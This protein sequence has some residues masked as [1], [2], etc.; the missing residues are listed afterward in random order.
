MKKTVLLLTAAVTGILLTSCNKEEAIL[1]PADRSPQN[2]EKELQEIF[3]E[4]MQ[5]YTSK[6]KSSGILAVP[7]E[8]NENPYNDAG[9]NHN[10]V[11]KFI[12]SQKTDDLYE[13]TDLVKSEF[14][15]TKNFDFT[16]DDVQNSVDLGFPL[17]IKNDMII[18][19]IYDSL[20]A[21][22]KISEKERSILF[23]TGKAFFDANNINQKIQIVKVAE[24]YILRSSD[25][26]EN[27]E[28][29]ML[30]SFAILRYS[31]YYWEIEV[32]DEIEFACAECVEF[33]D[34][35]AAVW[36]LHYGYTGGTSEENWDNSWAFGAFV[37]DLVSRMY[38][39]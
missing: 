14:P 4:T 8:N 30:V 29:R 20:V 18:S 36:A 24:K 37:S 34:E 23:T 6:E 32:G 21:D 17:T 2:V 7:L 22:N 35:S 27:A 1:S 38:G 33:A 10:S 11:L 16:A 25:I 12:H 19:D 31:T 15:E 26:S 28:M 5:K 3:A 39:W 9:I 13:L